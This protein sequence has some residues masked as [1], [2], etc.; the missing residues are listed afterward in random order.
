MVVV[1]VVV[2]V[3]VIVPVAV[4]DGAYGGNQ[5]KRGGTVEQWISRGRRVDVG[6]AISS[7]LSER[8]V[9]ER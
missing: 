3:V 7:P 2:M 1:V 5:D 4:I 8:A 9:T 6:E